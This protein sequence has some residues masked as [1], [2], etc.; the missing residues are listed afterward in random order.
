M[1]H[2][3]EITTDQVL[4]IEEEMERAADRAANNEEL[5]KYKEHMKRRVY[6]DNAVNKI[7]DEIVVPLESELMTDEELSDLQD[8]LY[9]APYGSD[10]IRND[11]AENLAQ[12]MQHMRGIDEVEE[13]EE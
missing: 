12:L 6:V 5:K 13:E 3:L 7:F 4:R 8:Y 2:I 1:S 9:S 10:V 11:I